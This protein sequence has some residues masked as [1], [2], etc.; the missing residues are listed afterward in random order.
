ML[1][2]KHVKEMS[3]DEYIKARPEKPV[4]LHLGCGGERWQDFINV[5]MNPH[6]PG[7]E[8]SSRSGCVADVFADMRNLGLPDDAVDEIFTVHTIDHFTRWEAIRMFR[9]WHRMLKPDGLLTV[10]VADFAR[11]ILWLFHPRKAMREVA[12]KQFYGNQ[13]DEIEYETHRYGWSARELRSVLT[14]IG[15]RTVKIHHRTLTHYPGRD[16]HVEARK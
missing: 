10:E 8:D 3:L 15:F 1:L 9:D 16:M 6:V 14:E 4:K 13:W 2:D 12:L 11:C 7:K 5:D